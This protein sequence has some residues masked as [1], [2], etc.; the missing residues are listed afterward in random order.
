VCSW[1]DPTALVARAPWRLVLASDVLYGQR[2]ID[3]LLDLLPRLAAADGEVWITDPCRPL[4][5][6][7]LAAARSTWR[8]VETRPTRQEDVRFHRLAS[9]AT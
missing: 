2:N 3:E 4:T 7:F 1:A 8:I 6:G 9:P 5:G